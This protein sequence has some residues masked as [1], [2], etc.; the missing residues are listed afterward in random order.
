MNTKFD[1]SLEPT[2]YLYYSLLYLLKST[3]NSLEKK[4]MHYFD[5]TSRSL[6]LLWGES[7]LLI[8]SEKAVKN[9]EN[10]YSGA[11]KDNDL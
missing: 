10:R 7:S 11:S 6:F 3:K 8:P 1:T 9:S 4:I 2:F 5:F